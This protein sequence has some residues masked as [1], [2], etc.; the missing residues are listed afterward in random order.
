MN[1]KPY[2]LNPNLLTHNPSGRRRVLEVMEHDENMIS[3]VS[4]AG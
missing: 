2:I 1:R 4:Y 3:L